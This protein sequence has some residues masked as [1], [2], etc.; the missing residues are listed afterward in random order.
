MLRTE[1]GVKAVE[2]SYEAARVRIEFYPEAVSEEALRSFITDIG[3]KAEE[4]K[5]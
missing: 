2:A 3:F 4:Q 1:K 5:G